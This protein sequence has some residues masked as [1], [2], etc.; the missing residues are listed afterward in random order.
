MSVS[1]SPV[2]N[3]PSSNSSANDPK[4]AIY[5][6]DGQKVTLVNGVSEIAA[7]PSS[8]TKI[9]TTYFGNA[10]TA[11]LNGDG[12][13]D[14]AFI[15]TQSTGGS[16]TFY[17]VVAALNMPTGYVGSQGLLLG[18][19][20]APQTTEMSQDKTTPNVIIVNYA[21]RGPGESFA[22]SPSIGKSLWLLLDPK[23]MQFGEVAQNFEGEAD[24]AKMTLDMKTWNWVDTTYNNGSTTVPRIQNKFA[25]T[26]KKPNI[27]SASTDCNGVGGEYSTNGNMIT[28]TKMMS[29]LMYCEGS[30]ESEFSKA[31]GEAESY[32]FTS[33][34]ELIFD[35]KF[36]SGTMVFK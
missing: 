32:H 5:I 35:L 13:L 22:V 16:G 14:S 27:F 31:L 25:L 29:T 1:I 23:T 28:F 12:R 15:L 34:G 30:Q 4:N 20:I 3:P 6:I 2:N 33:K 17:Y 24:S 26:F 19:R 21:V 7:A 8:A 10:V 9:I 36:D 11:D 18:D